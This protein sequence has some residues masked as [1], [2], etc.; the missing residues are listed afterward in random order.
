M[1]V[2]D[3][4]LLGWEDCVQNVSELSSCEKEVGLMS[5]KRSNMKTLFHIVT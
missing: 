3:S 1:H 2:T 4:V 5:V